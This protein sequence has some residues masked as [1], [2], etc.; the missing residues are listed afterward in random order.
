MTA[1]TTRTR[2]FS[3]RTGGDRGRRGPRPTPPAGDPGSSLVA[4]LPGGLSPAVSRSCH[5]PCFPAGGWYLPMLRRD[6]LLEPEQ[7][8]RVIF[9]FDRDE[10]LPGSG[11]IGFVDP[12]DAL[13]GQ[14]VHVC[15]RRLT[16]LER[17]PQAVDPDRALRR[18]GRLIVKS[19]DFY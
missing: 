11:W 6:V 1:S 4:R 3:N 14:E 17:L 5:L 10:S 19:C 9:A 12:R 18:L 15:R 8:R 2:S 7:L 13:I 16:I